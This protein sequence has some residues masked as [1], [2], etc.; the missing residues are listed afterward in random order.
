MPS[1]K[2]DDGL[3]DAERIAYAV[4]NP[5][6]RVTRGRVCPLC[7]TLLAV[8]DSQCVCLSSG[9]MQ[10]CSMPAQQSLHERGIQAK[11]MRASFR[12]VEEVL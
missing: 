8:S 2:G 11:K 10:T 7:E 12:R 1:F 6:A 9:L 3:S 4:C 5:V